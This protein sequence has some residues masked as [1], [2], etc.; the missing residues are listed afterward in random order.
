MTKSK[1][2]TDVKSS[3]KTDAEEFRRRHREWSSHSAACGP[4]ELASAFAGEFPFAPDLGG[5]RRRRSR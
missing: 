1:V 4:G 5:R 2:K 3:A